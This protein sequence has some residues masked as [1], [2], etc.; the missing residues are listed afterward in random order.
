MAASDSVSHWR[1]Y[2]QPLKEKGYKLGM[3]ATTSAPS[4]LQWVLDFMA[5]CPDCTVDFVPVHWY[6]VSA[7]GFK[8]Y[9]VSV[10]GGVAMGVAW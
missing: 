1:E 2:M 10:P 9:V 3:A 6:D 7:D 4:G 8:S 5:A